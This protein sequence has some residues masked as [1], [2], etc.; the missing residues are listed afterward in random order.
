[1]HAYGDNLNFDPRR[2]EEVQARLEVIR[3]LKRKYG[4]SV[5]EILRYLARAER[6]LEGL[7]YSGER[8]QK[9]EEE[10]GQLKKEM[11]NLASRISR[12]RN[13]A[14]RKLSGVVKKELAEL[15]MGRVDFDIAITQELSPEGIPFPDDKLYKYSAS[16]A[17]DIVFMAS[18]NPGEPLKPLDKIASTGEISRFL[19]ALKS[20][21][22]EAD[23]IPV[24]IFD[25]I[26]IGIGGRSGEVIGKKLWNLARHHQ[27]ICV[28]HLPQIAAFADAQYRVSKQTT[29]KRTVS[30]IE[31]IQGEARFKELAVM[32]AG[33]RYTPTA[34]NAAKELIE[35][36]ES[37]KKGAA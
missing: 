5:D 11:G 25:E 22:A 27:V 28:T 17:D 8:R 30:T 15:N 10:K 32:M 1:V 7:T 13:K 29:G 2:L 16:G 20:A 26:D 36:A 34:L 24:L 9:L 23:T 12:E 31:P 33:A 18:T 14:A 4:G 3:S 37:W 35:K 6:E 21:L 19:L